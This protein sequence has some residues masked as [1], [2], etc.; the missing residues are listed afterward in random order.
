V[1]QNPA[2]TPEEK[3]ERV[4]M[5]MSK[6]NRLAAILSSYLAAILFVFG[7]PLVHP[8]LHAHLDHHDRETTANGDH[9]LHKIGD[10]SKQK[11]PICLAMAS[12]K[13]GGRE[14]PILKH[15]QEP[16]HEPLGRLKSEPRV[17]FNPT[18]RYSRAPPSLSII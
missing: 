6:R 10:G 13:A 14:R 17:Q 9:G 7:I 12:L 2:E 5:L 16:L 3:V 15:G 8:V 1:R 4:A 18:N 11:C